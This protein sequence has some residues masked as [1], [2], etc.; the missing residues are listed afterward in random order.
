MK[1]L[2]TVGFIAVFI[3]V[4][5]FAEFLANCAGEIH[6]TRWRRRGAAL[7]LLMEFGGL[8][9]ALIYILLSLRLE[10]HR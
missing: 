5:Y 4:W 3:A 10:D 6:R 9:C 2:A 1:I 8:L 7:L